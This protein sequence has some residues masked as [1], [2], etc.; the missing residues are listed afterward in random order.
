MMR[1]ILFITCKENSKTLKYHTFLVR[2][3]FFCITCGKCDSNCKKIFKE[4]EST[5][6]LKIIG[7]VNN[8]N[9]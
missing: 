8:T 1:V 2:S 5:E 7:L 4:V 9:E 6:I 3:L